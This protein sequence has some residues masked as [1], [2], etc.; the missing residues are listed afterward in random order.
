MTRLA[1]SHE[2][3]ISI[4]LSRIVNPL[5]EQ[6]LIKDS[7]SRESKPFFNRSHTLNRYGTIATNFVE[8]LNQLTL[9]NKLEM[10]TLIPFSDILVTKG[11]L[12]PY[13][14]WCHICYQD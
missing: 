1:H 13:Q 3:S 14:A 9:Q 10:L 11:L 5:L 8:V 2:V 7:S 6:T 12:R 4:L